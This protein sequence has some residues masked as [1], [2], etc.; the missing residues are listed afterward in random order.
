[1]LYGL[2]GEDIAPGL[3]SPSEPL[4]GSE[5]HSAV[6]QPFLHDVPFLFF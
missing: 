5:A 6:P 3:G 1:M 4:Q 2:A